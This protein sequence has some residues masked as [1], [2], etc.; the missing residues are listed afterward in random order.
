MIDAE[1]QA[2][3]IETSGLFDADYYVRIN[4]RAGV[5]GDPLTHYCQSG[6]RAGLA[7][8]TVF[9]PAWYG[10][11]YGVESGATTLLLDYLERGAAAGRA[12]SCLFDPA[13]Y[14]ARYDVTSTEALAHY[15]ANRR[16]TSPN[17]FFD[18]AHYCAA[19]PDIVAA[20]I[21]P[22]EHFLT[23]GV[24]ESRR[25]S[26]LF[27]ADYV[28]RRYL[29]KDR[30]KN[31]FLIFMQFQAVLGWSGVP[32]ADEA[33]VAGEIRKATAPGPLF[34][35]LP[36][37]SSGLRAAKALAFY[38]PQFHAI[39]ENDLW[40]GAGFTEWRN[41][42]RGQPRFVGHY[43]PRVPRDL[44]YYELEG[45]VVLRRQV[46]LARNAGLFGFC[47]YY[48]NFNGHRLLERP[49]DA[50]VGDTAIGFPFCLMWANENWT[51]RWDGMEKD[52]LIAQD[53]RPE[54]TPALV[55]DLARYMKDARY[56]RIKD[57]PI[58]FVYRA[59]VIPD[60]M[61]TLRRWRDLFQLEHGLEPLFVMAQT[62][63]N[64]DPRPF[65][66]DAAV[67][68]PP[69]KFGSFVP[70]RNETVDILDPDF[71]GDVRGYD[72]FVA[73][74]LKDFPADYPLIK[75][76]FP[77][78][79]NDARKPG[80]SMVVHG[81]T[82]AK[83][84]AWVAAVAA[85][86]EAAPVLG[87]RLFCV[88]AWN[89]WCEGAYLESDV[90][91][92][93]AYLN[94][95]ARGIS[96]SRDVRRR[97]MLLVGHDAFPAGAQQLLY[98]IGLT[99]RYRFGLQI[100]F[101]LMGGGSLAKKYAEIAPTH[102]VDPKTDFWPGLVA[103]LHALREDGYRTALTNS[104]FSGNIVNVLTEMG[105]K[106]CSL[107]H[108]LRTIVAR[109]DGAER[110]KLIFA[111]SDHV[112]FPSTRVQEELVAAF[113]APAKVAAVLPQGVYKDV[114]EPDTADD[115]ALRRELGVPA[116]ARLVL[117]AGFADL[118][119]GVD[120]FVAIAKTVALIAPQV[121]FVWVGDA[122]ADVE[123]WLLAT[124]RA[125]ARSNMRFVP[126]T[127][128]IG[129]YMRAADLFL[130]TSREDPFPSVIL[131]ALAA[132]LPV[133]A[134]QGGGGFVDLLA[135]RKLGFL[136]PPDNL[137]EAAATIV[138]ELVGGAAKAAELADYRRDLMR[139][140]FDFGRYCFEVMRK[141]LPA[142]T[143]S[144][145]VPNY[146]YHGYLE[147][148]IAS[149]LNQT[150][151]IFEL[152]VLD[153]GST[154][155]SVAEIERVAG[156][157][158][159]ELVLIEN[160]VNSGNVFA[161]W[162]K[163]VAMA[164]GDLVWLAEADDL[165]DPAFLD[166]LAAFFARRDMALAFSDS[167]TVDAEG[168]T[169]W[170]S[171]KPYYDTLFP[172]ALSASAVFDGKTFLDDYLSVKNVILNASAVLWRRDVLAAALKACAD[173]LSRL[174]MAGDWRLYMQ[175]CTMGKIGYHASALNV[176]RRHESSVTHALKKDQHLGE[177]AYIHDLLR[178]RGTA[179]GELQARYIS[180]LETQ[181]GTG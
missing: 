116:A 41:T 84:Q 57:R 65:G 115:L 73:A 157:F 97:K 180:E 119:K 12:P 58:L 55:A 53:Y 64:T 171:Y 163:G 106:I 102:V 152:I 80:H 98:H 6:E 173:D 61:E 167:S 88:N 177:V 141:T 124:V 7:P 45:T 28:W 159:R 145:I 140:D 63:G 162:A 165:A 69:H 9:A 26:T 46:E 137:A 31:P 85:K 3:V 139:S 100:A 123:T 161:Q 47:F 168:L 169:Q 78:W 166:E 70:P 49:L 21:D 25:P 34:E 29:N 158:R 153:D 32:E 114:E 19:Y 128:R 74:S 154:D 24:F 71:A 146:N 126:F 143:I 179:K 67:E 125:D 172:G 122:D 43:Q 112:V 86:A 104:A 50:Y 51:R 108:E 134:F 4:P 14:A 11:T 52:V 39:P 105:F 59:D 22:F 94:A 101:V 75:T 20:G 130:L 87:E 133:A 120:L 79:D 135:D 121:V 1:T 37:M 60:T 96:R 5:I 132:G 13:W 91:Y 181:F 18:T 83:F 178:K 38:L 68:F 136:L 81:S 56:I 77:S 54:D 27:D 99:L 35:E 48:Y 150:H 118:R 62:F 170:R 44:G 138:R 174:R 8:S 103:H 33:S 113:G 36:P 82:P 30:R 155:D 129:R 15:M 90:H 148:R 92:G 72:D 42:T 142:R 110:L 117:N 111:H 160:P 176:H 149:I 23:Q 144:V 76:V 93:Y 175:A 89:E 16:V 109:D 17:P 151:P 127:D 156:A 2:S 66:F 164:K 147:A 131:E 40:W 107:I 10:S 95:F